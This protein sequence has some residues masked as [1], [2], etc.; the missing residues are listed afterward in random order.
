MTQQ[1]PTSEAQ[2]KRVNINFTLYAK[3]WPIR[4][5]TTPTQ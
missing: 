3:I 1:H 5:T 2:Q 4:Q